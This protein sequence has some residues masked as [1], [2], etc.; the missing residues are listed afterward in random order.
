[1]I[2]A[3]GKMTVVGLVLALAAG[4]GASRAAKDGRNAVR[5]G[6]W[7]AAVAHMTKAVQDD[8]DKP[9]YKIELE[10]AML[11]SSYVHLE[12]ARQ[13]DQQGQFESAIVEY[14]RTTEFDPSNR[15]AMM[16][17]AELERLVRDRQ[18]AERP[19]PLID[20]MKEQAR[21]QSQPLLNP[22]SREPLN[23]RFTQASTQDILNFIG[24]A[25]GINVTFERDF[26][27]AALL[28][29][30]GGRDAGGGAHADH[31]RQPALVQGDQ[32]AHDHGDPRQQ[33][34]AAGLRGPGHPHVLHLPR[35]PSGAVADAR[36]DHPHARHGRAADGRRQQDV[37][38]H[39][40][41][42]HQGRRGDHREGDRGQRQAA[43]RG[44]HR[45]RTAGGQPDPREAVRH[46]PH[47]VPGRRDLLAR[48]APE[49]RGRS[50]GRHLSPVQPQHDH[51]RDQHGGLLHG[52]AAGRRSLP[53]DRLADAPDLEAA[54][55]RLRGTEAHAEPGRGGAGA[56]RRSSRPLP[57]AAPRP[58]R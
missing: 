23:L 29:P 10:R 43:R 13:L 53:G 45:R 4:C 2:R 5:A 6:D 32:R 50:G 57:R 54:A 33:P 44:A 49:H 35:G 25:A 55:A 21:R 48:G 7:D 1:M 58:T 20:A 16:R 40:G 9:E 17:A 24:S 39:H 47:A 42:R 30:A 26:R 34:E 12:R 15:G 22:A 38:H 27:P 36:A 8:P 14:R 3:L 51:A 41:A 19:K 46:Q 28:D 56:R 52:G 11:Q 31:G 18:E 37:E